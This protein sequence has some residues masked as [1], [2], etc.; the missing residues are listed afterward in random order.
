MLGT[1][2]SIKEGT[3]TYMVADPFLYEFWQVGVF[4]HFGIR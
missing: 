3:Y 2:E 1:S 4:V